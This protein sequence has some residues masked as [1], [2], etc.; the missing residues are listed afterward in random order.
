MSFP[1]PVVTVGSALYSLQL[2]VFCSFF[3]QIHPC[4]P[5]AEVLHT[6]QLFASAPSLP[7]LA[8]AALC[9]EHCLKT[10]PGAS[11]SCREPQGAAAIPFP[12]HRGAGTEEGRLAGSTGW[13]CVRTRVPV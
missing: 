5:Q 2:E 3:F 12:K 6:L 8:R 1:L 13:H 7:S 10:L 4:P 11:A 9:H